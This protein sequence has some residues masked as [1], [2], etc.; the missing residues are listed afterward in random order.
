MLKSSHSSG[1]RRLTTECQTISMCMSRHEKPF[2]VNA[3]AKLSGWRD[4]S[5][6]AIIAVF[7]PVVV[8]TGIL[9]PLQSQR[10]ETRNSKCVKQLLQTCRRSRQRFIVLPGGGISGCQVVIPSRQLASI[11]LTLISISVCIKNV[12]TISSGKSRQQAEE[13]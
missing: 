6:W 13:K 11:Q 1:S 5:F 7:V 10:L 3:D 12:H 8:P 4:N 9:L 2:S